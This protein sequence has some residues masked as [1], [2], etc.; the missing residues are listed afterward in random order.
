MRERERERERDRQRERK[1]ERDRERQTERDRETD[2]QT[3]RQRTEAT[4]CP[5]DL[6]TTLN[7]KNQPDICS[8]T[9][10]QTTP[11]LPVP[12]YKP[13]HHSKLT[14]PSLPMISLDRTN[15]PCI[16]DMA[17]ASYMFMLTLSQYLFSLAL[18]L[19]AS[20]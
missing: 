5:S 6:N 1:A 16:A 11:L 17:V 2:R 10:S 3:D 13:Y 9:S 15:V 14:R 4:A 18:S 8:R 7:H 12:F 19:R 20:V